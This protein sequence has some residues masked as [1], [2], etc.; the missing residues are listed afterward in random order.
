[1]P[2]ASVDPGLSCARYRSG[3]WL[4]ANKPEWPPALVENAEKYAAGNPQG[5]IVVPAKGAGLDRSQC[6]VLLSQPGVGDA[7][8]CFQ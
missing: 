3:E 8:P 2:L 1:M 4:P 5:A 6:S 7:V